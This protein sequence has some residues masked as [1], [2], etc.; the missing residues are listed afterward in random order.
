[1]NT[2]ETRDRCED[3]LDSLLFNSRVTAYSYRIDLTSCVSQQRAN[4][5][6]HPKLDA[7]YSFYHDVQDVLKQRIRGAERLQMGRRSAGRSR[8]GSTRRDT[9]AFERSRELAQR[10]ARTAR[11]PRGIPPRESPCHTEPRRAAPCRHSARAF[12]KVLARPSKV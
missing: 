8:N 6:K 12:R 10:T 1:M 4:S 2:N 5:K 7:Q 9:V 11:W 3:L